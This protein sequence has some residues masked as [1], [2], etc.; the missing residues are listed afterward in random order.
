MPQTGYTATQLYRTVTSGGV[1]VNTDL[2]AGELAINTLDMALFALNSSGAVKR[3]MNNPAGLKY[4][5]AD[6]SAGQA[7]VTDGSGTMTFLAL[8]AS[9]ALVSDANGAPKASSVTATELGYLSGVT[10]AIQTQLDN[11][12]RLGP[13]F[14]A[15]ASASQ[16]IGAVTPTKI[17]FDTARFDTKSAYNAST[18]VFTPQ[19]QGYYQINA[20]V[21]FSGS[22]SIYS[23]LSL[24]K[25]GSVYT[26]INNQRSN[27]N[28]NTVSW[29][30]VVY[31]NGSTDYLEVYAYESLASSTVAGGSEFSGALIG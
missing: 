24:Y 17:H 26:S 8:T 30:G 6:G 21:T 20:V 2:V 7:V 14:D 22:S 13:I 15:Y 25:N 18:Y 9:K 29:S 31:M 12:V 19:T 16:S 27:A 5:T 23:L 3:I 4:P 11:R 10:S 1:P 28:Y